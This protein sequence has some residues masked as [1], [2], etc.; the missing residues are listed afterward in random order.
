MVFIL[1]QK[2]VLNRPEH[3]YLDVDLQKEDWI[4][5]ATRPQELAEWKATETASR[6]RI[7]SHWAQL[8][9]EA[10]T[11]VAENERVANQRVEQNRKLK[12][13][14]RASGGSK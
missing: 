7:K 11:Q 10:E 12:S 6:Q 5:D 2:S 9:S 13:W 14:T 1:N 3:R 8:M 4:I